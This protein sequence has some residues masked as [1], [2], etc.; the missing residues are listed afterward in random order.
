MMRKLL[1]SISAAA[2]CFSVESSSIEFKRAQAQLVTIDPAN[3]I[4]QILQLLNFV[5]QLQSMAEDLGLQQ[6]QLEELEEMLESIIGGRDMGDILNGDGEYEYRR[7]LPETMEEL[8]GMTG[9]H[10]GDAGVAMDEYYEDYEP[11]DGDL[12]VGEDFADTY[13]YRAVNLETQA[14]GASLAAAEVFYEKARKRVENIET[15]M[16][17]INETEDLKA[18]ADLQTRVNAEQAYL[19]SELIQIQTVMLNQLAA[20]NTAKRA[21]ERANTVSLSNDRE[22]VSNLY[23]PDAIPDFGD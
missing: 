14:T 12:L 4:Q 22:A 21:E 8:L 2:I 7:S 23:D 6:D 13:I 1:Y 5:E 11:A 18:S 19:M 3:L 10:Y 20:E 9:D 15:L 16:G 17:I